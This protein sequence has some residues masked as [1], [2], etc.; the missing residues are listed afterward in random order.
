[1]KRIPVITA[2]TVALL[3]AVGACGGSGGPRSAVGSNSNPPTSPTPTTAAGV[4]PNAPEVNSAGDIPDDQVFVA[5]TPPS[6]GYGVRVPEGWARSE[7][8]GTVV[9][10]DK[11][12]S[13]RMESVAAARAPSTQS[14]EQEEVPAIRAASRDFEPGNVSEVTR[15]AGK[16]IL[17]TYRAD[18]APDPVTAKV[19][20]LDV[21]RYELWRGGTQVTLTLSGPQ[22]ADNVDP[23]RIVTDSF[24]WR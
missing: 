18:G 4:D 1:M 23:W 11:L 8:D 9:F 19:L 5:Y 21:E 6:G 24:Q 22:G 17:I 10:T 15:K 16:A 14:A 12:N 2:A 3:L 7:T 13:F 20:H